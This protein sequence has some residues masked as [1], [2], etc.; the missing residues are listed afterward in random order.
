MECGFLNLKRDEDLGFRV[1]N[2]KLIPSSLI[3]ELL[4]ARLNKKESVRTFAKRFKEHGEKRLRIAFKIAKNYM[5][6]EKKSINE[7]CKLAFEEIN[8][9]A[10]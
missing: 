9:F 7:A 10:L 4:L 6:R 1:T 8:K 5:E 2:T 3:K